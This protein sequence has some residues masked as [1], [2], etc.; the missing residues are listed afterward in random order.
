M[1]PYAEASR[2]CAKDSAD[3]SRLASLSSPHAV[4]WLRAHLPA[5]LLQESE[6]HWIGLRLTEHVGILKTRSANSWNWE[7]GTPVT[8][9]EW[10][11]T[12]NLTS[13]AERDICFAFAKVIDFVVFFISGFEP[14]SF[15]VS[16]SQIAIVLIWPVHTVQIRLQRL[17]SA[18]HCSSA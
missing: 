1:I 9:A 14:C 7:A 18:S 2:L 16:C 15:G 11:Q 13:F 6:P 5:T 3:S 4:A 12:P 17:L 10:A 8:H